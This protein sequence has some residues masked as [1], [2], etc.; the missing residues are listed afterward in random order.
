MAL[1]AFPAATPHIGHGTEDTSFG[2]SSLLIIL[3]QCFIAG[4]V[5]V[6]SWTL[7]EF[8]RANAETIHHSADRRERESPPEAAPH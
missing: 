7:P 6:Q 2:L 4:G 3:T 8:S 5:S 1:T